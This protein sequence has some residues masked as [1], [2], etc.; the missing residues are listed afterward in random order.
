MKLCFKYKKKLLN[1]KKLNLIKKFCDLLQ[2]KLPLKKDL[3]IVFLEKKQDDMTTG[4]YNKEKSRIRVLFG[5][6]MMADILRTL[7]HEWSHAYDSEKLKISLVTKTRYLDES[8]V[9]VSSNMLTPCAY[10]WAEKYPKISRFV[11]FG[12]T[13]FI[14]NFVKLFN[15]LLTNSIAALPVN[16]L[17]AI[18]STN[19]FNALVKSPL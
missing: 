19:L 4:S 11:V 17:F 12:H 3:T 9:F 2:K 1:D 18:F 15:R 8:G 10:F 7:S 13:P 16:F 6:R 14:Q 5:G